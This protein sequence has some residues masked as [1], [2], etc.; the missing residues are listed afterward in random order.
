MP[1]KEERIVQVVFD[2]RMDVAYSQAY[3]EPIDPDDIVD[4][5]G[6]FAGQI[7]GLLG[8]GE[9]GALYL[10]TGVHTGEVGFRLV[11]ADEAPALADEWEEVVEASFISDGPSVV[12]QWGGDPLCE[13][14]L[15]PV[16]HRV[17]Y[18]ARGMDAGRDA[19]VVMSHEPLV[20][21]YELTFWP[22]EPAPEEIVRQ[23]SSIAAYWHDARHH[24]KSRQ[25]HIQAWWGDNPPSERLIDVHQARWLV[26]RRRDLAEDLAVASP[27]SQR[28]LAYWAARLSCAETEFDQVDWVAQ[29]LRF[30]AR[31]EILPPWFGQR[32]A[33]DEARQEALGSQ[34]V[35]IMQGREIRKQVDRQ[36]WALLALA[37][38]DHEEP[39]LAALNALTN[40]ASALGA[41]REAAFLDEA[42]DVLVRT[43]RDQAGPD[44]RHDPYDGDFGARH[45]WG[46]EPPHPR[47]LEVSAHELG[48]FDRALAERLAEA[49]PEVQR[50]IARWAARRACTAAGL[51][52]RFPEVALALSHLD[53]GEPLPPPFDGQGGEFA[54]LRS[55]DEETFGS[56]SFGWGDEVKKRLYFPENPVTPENELSKDTVE[57]DEEPNW[58]RPHYTLSVIEKAAAPDPLF[59]ATQALWNAACSFGNEHRR[60]ILRQASELFLDGRP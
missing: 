14:E 39:L 46:D 52:Q 4:H 43:G 28:A 49:E 45:I 58:S 7:N 31:D 18:C 24:L 22:A 13:F 25:R 38:A 50:S 1:D 29:A 34:L 6:A 35:T 2:G 51:T 21:H 33:I 37:D 42:V 10:T 53:R 19:D 5:E 20:D 3:V 26:R 41:E 27:G 32:S 56:V 55:G 9:A 47:L 60:S 12:V 8:A 54:L 17:R 44:P 30:Q 16:P 40:G 15:P 36:T 11:I 23:G 59:A 48:M 57:V